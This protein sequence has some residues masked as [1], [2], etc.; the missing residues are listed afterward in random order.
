MVIHFCFFYLS[1]HTTLT[2][3]TARAQSEK[4]CRRR[5]ASS[6]QKTRRGIEGEKLIL[7]AFKYSGGFLRCWPLARDYEWRA[8][9]NDA[10]PLQDIVLLLVVWARINRIFILTARLHCPHCCNTIARLLGNMRPRTWPPLCMPYTIQYW[11]WQYRVKAKMT[12]CSVKVEGV[13]TFVFSV[14]GALQLLSK[15]HM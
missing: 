13:Y 12:P 15:R 14:K 4:H 2:P 6:G 3:Q 7:W 5:S 9:R 8:A 11:Q 1:W 10:W